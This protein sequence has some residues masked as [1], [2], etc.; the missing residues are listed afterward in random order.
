M[1][2]TRFI[3]KNEKHEIKQKKY[4]GLDSLIS[5][6]INLDRCAKGIRRTTKKRGKQKKGCKNVT[7][8][9][10]KLYFDSIQ[11]LSLISS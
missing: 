8:T 4:F 11:T 10:E 7:I 3:Q 9:A 2:I 5:L 6:I 1:T